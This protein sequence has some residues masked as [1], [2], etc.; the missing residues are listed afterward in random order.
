MNKFTII[1]ADSFIWN[2]NELLKFLI[3]NQNGNILIDTNGEGCCLESIGLYDILS[4]FNF[5]SVTI[6]TNNILEKHNKYNI[7]GNKFFKFFDVKNINYEEFHGWNQNKIVGV[8]YNRPSWHRIGL[9]SELMHDYADSSLVN[10][11]SDPHDDDVRQFFEI[12]RLFEVNPTSAEKFFQINHKLPVQLEEIDGYTLG[13]TTKQHTD[14]LCHFY[15]HIFV[16]LVAETFINGKTF[17]ATEKTV[18]PMLLKKPFIIMG[19]KNFLIY[20]R[21]MGFRTFHDF[22]DE[23]YDGFDN[24]FRRQANLKYQ[25]ILQIVKLINSKSTNELETMYYKMQEILNHNYNI[26][27]SK[28]YETQIDYVK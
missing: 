21:Q 12:Q 6:N 7:T 24:R 25:K 13:A 3:D 11:R 9:V 15:P 8:F 20:L 19:P 26:L 16:D 2:K 17:F 28:Q 18:R 5:K 10:F 22:W 23:D 4:L 27:V 14:Q 1:P